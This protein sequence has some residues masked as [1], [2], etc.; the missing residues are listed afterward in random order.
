MGSNDA[1]KV[2]ALDKSFGGKKILDNLSFSVPLNVIAGFLGPNGAGKTTTLRMLLGLLPA[3]KGKI[4]LLNHKIPEARS[5]ALEK[6]GAVVENPSFIETLTAFE[7]LHWFGSLYAPVSG[8]R[9]NEVIELV[10]LKEATHQLFG[11]FSTGMKQRLGVAFGLLHKPEM[12]I[13]DEPT[14]GMDPAG[15]IQMRE[16]LLNIH[17]TEKTSI[18]LSSHL[19]DEVQKL[20]NYVVIINHGSTIREGYVAD[21][22]SSQE[23]R[24]EIRVPDEAAEKAKN[25]L[26]G[27]K[28][29]VKNLSLSPRGIIIDIENG[30]SSLINELLVKS[31]IP[32]QALIPLESSLE[33][34]FMRLTD[35]KELVGSKG[36]REVQLKNSVQESE[37]KEIKQNQKEEIQ[38]EKEEKKEVSEE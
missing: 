25:L 35:K 26:A 13:L 3:P 38:K 32:V 28:D 27:M 2:T 24:F 29:V 30:N 14:S 19:L 15:R 18:F 23:E 8:E 21:I 5:S 10:G 22:L 20:C 7:N 31:N 1:I 9:I 17:E 34:A 12:L 16:I 33:E 4:E 36:N 6:I 11:T 37:N